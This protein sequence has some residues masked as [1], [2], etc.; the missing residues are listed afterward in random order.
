MGADTLTIYGVEIRYAD[1]FY[2]PT[3]EEAQESV[4]I[5][6]AVRQFVRAKLSASGLDL[7]TRPP[8]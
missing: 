4:A 5:A 3:P 8:S 2:L 7:P 1:D 6:Q